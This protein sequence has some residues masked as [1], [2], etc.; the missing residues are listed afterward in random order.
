MLPDGQARLVLPHLVMFLN[1]KT[2]IMATQLKLLTRVTGDRFFL[3]LYVEETAH[4][5]VLLQLLVSR[6]AMVLKFQG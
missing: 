4:L 1:F 3:E 2:T 5:R 6:Q